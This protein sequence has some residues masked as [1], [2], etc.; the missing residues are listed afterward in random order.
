MERYLFLQTY[1]PMRTPWCTA[2]WLQ[3]FVKIKYHDNPGYLR[4]MKDSVNWKILLELMSGCQVSQFFF[5]KFRPLVN[6]DEDGS[7][8]NSNSFSL[9]CWREYFYWL[10]FQIFKEEE[11]VGQEH[12]MILE[13]A[14]SFSSRFLE[15]F[16]ASTYCLHLTL[17]KCNFQTKQRRRDSTRT[18][19]WEPPVCTPEMN[20]DFFCYFS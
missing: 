2:A 13:N 16:L 5:V 18:K 19:I 14:V 3:L 10:S 7:I 11:D 8:L 12:D 1:A 4:L 20:P 15:N 17:E 6:M 9:P